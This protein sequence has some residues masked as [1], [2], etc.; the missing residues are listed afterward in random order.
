MMDSL[1]DSLTQP[2]LT[3]LPVSEDGP[4]VELLEPK[5]SPETPETPVGKFAIYGG[6]EAKPT[7]AARPP[8]R[9]VTNGRALAAKRMLLLPE[10][11]R[12]Y[13]QSVA[14]RRHLAARAKVRREAERSN[15]SSKKR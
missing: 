7:E 4:P 2:P 1:I 9:R 8:I 11:I 14:Y 3:S 5:E 6:T 10:I 12:G 15:R 13:Y